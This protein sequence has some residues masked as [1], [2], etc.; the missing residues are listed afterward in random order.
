MSVLLPNL[1]TPPPDVSAPIVTSFG[2]TSVQTYQAQS[3][4]HHY[5]SDL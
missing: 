5:L 4:T 2:K 1:S 3:T